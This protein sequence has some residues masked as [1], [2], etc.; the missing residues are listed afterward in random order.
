[1]RETLAVKLVFEP[2]PGVE[3]MQHD[4]GGSEVRIDVKVTERKVKG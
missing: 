2:L 4:I 3:P 1:M